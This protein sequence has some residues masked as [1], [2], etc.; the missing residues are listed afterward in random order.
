MLRRTDKHYLGGGDRVVW[1]PPF[2]VW[3]DKPGFWDKANFYN[4]DLEPVFT[5]TLLNE[6]GCEIPVQFQTREWNP[7]RLK[8]TYATDAGFTVCEEKAVMPGDSLVSVFTFRNETDH[9]IE[10]HYIAWTTQKSY[11]SKGKEFIDNLDMLNDK[12]MFT[13]FLQMRDLPLCSIHCAFGINEGI[14][15]FAVN[16]SQ[17]T[18]VHPVWQSTPFYDHFSDGKLNNSIK[19]SGISQDGL[20]YMAL[21]KKLTLPSGSTHRIHTATA[22]A[23][24]DDDAAELLNFSLRYDDPVAVSEG[25][26]RRYF[27]GL[28]QFHCSDPFLTTYYWYRWYGLRLFTIWGRSENNY[29]FPAICEGVSYFRVPITYSAQC[30]IRETRWKQ[31][32]EIA[33]GSLLNFINM[34]REDGSFVGHIYPNGVQTDGFYHADWGKAVLAVDEIHPDINFLEQAYHGLNRYAAYFDRERDKEDSGLYDVVDQ[35]ETGQEY[36]SRYQ[37]VDDK[38]DTYGW[39]NNIQI[40]R[41]SCRERV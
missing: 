5:I 30:H 27:A 35:F 6:H 8:Q 7:A 41:A 12:I 38:A 18:A 37:A 1:T 39:I 10:L 31:S 15:S 14:D 34:Q 21:H 2:P 36:M 11:P 24:N 33:H 28:P 40:G 26:W 9:S 17:P 22:F 13:K 32:P 25:N 19:I 16:F 3:L 29:A 20:I 23:K 4:F